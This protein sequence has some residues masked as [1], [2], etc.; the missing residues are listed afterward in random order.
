MIHTRLGILGGGQLARMLAEAAHPLGLNLSIFTSGKNDPA[1]QVC[2]STFAGTLDNE[3]DLKAFSSELDVVTFE[4]EFVDIEK[5]Q[6][7]LPPKTYVFPNLKA[8]ATIQDRLT[9]KQLLDRFRI[10]TSPWTP[11]SSQADLQHVH[12]MFSRGFV[13]KKRRFGYDG[14]GTF[15]FKSGSAPTEILEKSKEGFI[16][17]GFVPFKRELALSFVRSRSG[18]FVSLPL[19]ESVQVDSRCFSVVGPVKHPGVKK[20]E[21]AFKK[22]MAEL[23]YVGIL[24]VELF[25]DGK[26]LLVNELAPRVHNSA[27]YSI[28]ALTCSQ[29]EYHLRAGLD[30]PLP[31]V[32]LIRPGFAMVNLLGEGQKTRLSFKPVG[33]L[34]WYG[35]SENRKGRKLGHINTTDR[36]P[37]A[38]LKKALRWR[39]DFTL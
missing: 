12:E 33:Q 24:A 5:L 10:P 38:A 18:A 26:N 31:K 11:V 30:L 14:Y 19:V 32:E 1:A 13:L 6:R 7:S 37:K 27:H 3:D 28:D 4:S 22:M 39:K 35:K 23:D 17:E 21:R 36:N 16:A 34:H 2:G 25:D 9:Q 29:F 8:I 20:L 15:V